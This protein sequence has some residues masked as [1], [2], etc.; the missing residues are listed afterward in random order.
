[1]AKAEET[2]VNEIE[3]ESD[4]FIREIKEQIALRAQAKKDKNYALADEIRANLEAKGVILTDTAPGT[5][6]TIK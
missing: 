5:K 6:F 3:E 1:M 2:A 4:P